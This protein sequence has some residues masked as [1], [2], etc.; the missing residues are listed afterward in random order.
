MRRYFIYL[1]G[2]LLVV[3]IGMQFVPVKRT[4]RPGSG[5]PPA[6]RN[7]QWIL[8]RACYD[9]HSTETRWPVWAYVAPM[10]WQVVADVDR[11]RKFVNF[12]DWASY[13][14]MYRKALKMNI[15]RVN[16]TH[17]MPLWYYVTLHPDAKLSPGDRR[18]I[19]EWAKSPD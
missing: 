7:V 15:D 11:A 12:S 5:D 16:A 9:C 19:A 13:D 17:R 3:F 4:N 1:A 8:R 2:L 6:P 10:S 14:P 18:A